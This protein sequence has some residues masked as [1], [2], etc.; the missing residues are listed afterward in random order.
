M[1]WNRVGE[2]KGKAKKREGFTVAAFL[3]SK[4]SIALFLVQK[5]ALEVLAR[6]EGNILSVGK[7]RDIASLTLIFWLVFRFLPVCQAF[8]GI[9]SS[10]NLGIRGFFLA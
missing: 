8:T 2:W 4:V 9:H 7:E 1:T 6:A 3:L 5:I 10:S